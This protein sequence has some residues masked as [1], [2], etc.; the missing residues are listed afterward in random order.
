MRHCFF[1]CFW[2]AKPEWLFLDFSGVT[3]ENIW[4]LA[5]IQVTPTVAYR[6][7]RGVLTGPWATQMSC[8]AE[9]PLSMGDNSQKLQLS[10]SLPK[11][12]AFPPQ[13]ILFPMTDLR[14]FVTSW[15]LRF[16]LKHSCCL[17]ISWASSP[18]QEQMFL[19]PGMTAWWR[20]LS[21]LNQISVLSCYLPS[22]GV[23]WPR[24]VNEFFHTM[25]SPEPD[26]HLFTTTVFTQCQ[27]HS[28]F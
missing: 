14:S 4:S 15:A 5:T 6:S 10:M 22:S 19:L 18:V 8:I 23:P 1:A 21:F 2:V 24:L 13:I 11:V 28:C 25:K 16:D 26:L 17:W 3:T 20:C 12:Q 27:I 7:G 9:G